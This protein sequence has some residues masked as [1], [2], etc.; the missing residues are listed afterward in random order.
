LASAALTVV[1]SVRREFF[2][3]GYFRI[4][5]GDQL[6]SRLTRYAKRQQE[7]VTLQPT[8]PRIATNPPI[9]SNKPSFDFASIFGRMTARFRSS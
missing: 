8:S 2:T 3:G 7:A 1:Q 9:F 4:P 5:A 6:K